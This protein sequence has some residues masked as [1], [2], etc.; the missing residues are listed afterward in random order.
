M[1][2]TLE[3]Q[4]LERPDIRRLFGIVRRRHLQFLI[5]LFLGWLGVW[6]TSWVLPPRYKSSTTILVDNPR[7]RRVMLLPISM[8]TCRPAWRV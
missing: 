6:G 4:D 7:C 2:E 3:E 8:T 5:P 1:A